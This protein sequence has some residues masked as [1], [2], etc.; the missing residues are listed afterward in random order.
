MLADFFYHLR[1]HKLSVSVK[2]YLTLLEALS[3]PL[4]PPSLEDFYYLARVTLIKDET[5]FDRF[6]R[7]FAS[8]YK[9][10]EQM[11]PPSKE[12]PLDWLMQELKKNLTAEQKAGLEKHGL[13]KLLEMFKERLEEQHER[14][15][16]GSKW[17]GTGGTSPFGN[18]GFNPA[19]IRVGK[20]SAGNRTALKVW[21]ERQFQ[22]YDDTIELGTRNIKVALKRLRRFAREGSQLEL[23]LDETIISTAR[24]AGYLDIKMVPERHNNIKVLMLL[25]VGGSMDDH[26]TRVEELFSAARSEFKNLEVFYFH[27]CPYEYLWKSNRRRQIERFETQDVLR[28]FNADWR[29]ILVGDATMGPSEILQPGGSVEHHNKEPGAQWLQRIITSW[30]KAVWLNPEPQSAWQYR[31]S[32]SL[33]QNIVQGK[34]FP[35]T[36]SGVEQAMRLL[37]K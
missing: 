37:S 24:N 12:I 20:D 14:H 10:L 25:D 34:M 9:K 36:V 2:E 19:G 3:T 21:D 16:G 28:K 8:Y 17:I 15:E 1:H 23:D 27:N 13:E 5:L 30:P 11:L 4:M 22:D 18:S 32:I 29:L 7:A 6:D 26:I 31:Y 33:I 35:V